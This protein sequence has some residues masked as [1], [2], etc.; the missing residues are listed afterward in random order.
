LVRAR[1][2]SAEHGRALQRWQGRS[3]ADLAA[4]NLLTETSFNHDG[5]ANPIEKRKMLFDRYN[6]SAPTASESA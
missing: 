4:A 5:N 6:W 3:V 2:P 1:T